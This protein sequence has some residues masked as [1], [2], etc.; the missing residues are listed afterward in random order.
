[1]E[2]EVPSK[3]AVALRYNSEEY[4]APRVVAKG[5]GFVAE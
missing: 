2:R 3:K 5:V 4:E 1:M